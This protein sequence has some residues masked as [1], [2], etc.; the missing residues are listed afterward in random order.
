MQ[1]WKKIPTEEEY[2][3]HSEMQGECRPRVSDVH[4]DDIRQV[5]VEHSVPVSRTQI[6]QIPGRLPLKPSIHTSITLHRRRPTPW[7]WILTPTNI[8]LSNITCCELIHTANWFTKVNPRLH[9]WL[10]T[11]GVAQAYRPTQQTAWT[12]ILHL[13][14]RCVETT[15]GTVTSHLIATSNRSRLHP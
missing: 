15:P 11:F 10:R 4:V 13:I 5:P 9:H 12:T 3:L 14:L 6:H 1:P 7:Q 8:T 2:V